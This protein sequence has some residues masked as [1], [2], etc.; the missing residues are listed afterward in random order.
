MMEREWNLCLV[1]NH[2]NI[3][4]IVTKEYFP[5]F[6]LLVSAVAAH[7]PGTTTLKYN[8]PTGAERAVGNNLGS[9]KVYH[10]TIF[11]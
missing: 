8:G 9:E 3:V 10:A 6:R 1:H 11:R 2:S 5:F 7:F 4:L